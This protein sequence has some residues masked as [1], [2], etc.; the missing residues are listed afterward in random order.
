MWGSVAIGCYA[1]ALATAGASD[2]VRYEIPNA[3]SLLLVGAFVLIAPSLPLAAAGGHVAAAALVFVL[4]S[5][6]FAAG[7]C[8]GGDVKLLAATAL[9]MG[10]RHLAAFV[11]L[12]ALVGAALALGLLA[13]RWVAA[14]WPRLRTGRWY[15]RLL[16]DGEGVPYGVAIAI[17]GLALLSELGL[18]GLSPAD[19]N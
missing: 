9:W 1:A 17:S 16:R 7:I 18:T 8:G 6:A 5:L 3:A 2:L 19:V 13:A 11:V 4:A 15:S 14:R 10:W 12:T